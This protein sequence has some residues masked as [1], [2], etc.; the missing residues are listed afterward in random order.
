MVIGMS[1]C[2]AH[3]SGGQMVCDQCGLVWDRDDDDPPVC[4]TN[5]IQGHCNK[6]MF[7]AGTEGRR[8]MIVD[9]ELGDHNSGDHNSGDHNSGDHDE[10]MQKIKEV[11]GD[12]NS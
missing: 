7:K 1:G 8:Y 5:F 4:K 3:Y 12:E 11:L 10:E 9:D 2:K 6:E